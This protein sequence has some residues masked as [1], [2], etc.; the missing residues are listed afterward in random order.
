[1]TRTNKRGLKSLGGG[2]G[3]GGRR[4]ELLAKQSKGLC[5]PLDSP[6][7]QPTVTFL[8][9]EVRVWFKNPMKLRLMYFLTVP[10]SLS[11]PDL[12]CTHIQL[13]LQCCLSPLAPKWSASCC[14]VLATP[15]ECV[16]L[17]SQ[18]RLT[19]MCV[20]SRVWCSLNTSWT[21]LD[22]S[23]KWGRLGYHMQYDL[24]NGVASV[25]ISNNYDLWKG[26]LQLSYAI[27]SV[28]WGHFSYH[29]Q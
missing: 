2:G 22:F 25:V 7:L 4:Q 10:I 19:F 14:H 20:S 16:L 28:A 12:P 6:R 9:F 17:G 1:M 8:S 21:M 15:A 24:W 26:S 5:T 29:M 11:S 3:R 18:I 23:W 13:C 27:S